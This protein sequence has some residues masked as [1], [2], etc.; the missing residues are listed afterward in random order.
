MDTS[1]IKKNLLV[2]GLV[3]F[4]LLLIIINFILFFKIKHSQTSVVDL[5][6]EKEITQFVQ[7]KKLGDFIR[8][9][10]KQQS[11][12]SAQLDSNCQNV[13]FY[14]PG[15]GSKSEK[16]KINT[17]FTEYLYNGYIHNYREFT[18]DNCEYS[19]IELSFLDADENGQVVGRF[20]DLILPKNLKNQEGNLFPA[21]FK[22]LPKK[23]LEFFITYEVDRENRQLKI[24]SWELNRVFIN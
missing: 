24:I 7:A 22:E 11:S 5:E 19:L 8:E 4:F 16:A 1:F 13:D 2:L 3:A 14:D 15:I 18:K 12:I 6:K 20:T 9:L 17:D 10:K 23:H 21:F